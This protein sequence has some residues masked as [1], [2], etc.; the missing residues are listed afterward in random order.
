ML[1]AVKFLHTIIWAFFNLVLVY[2]FY[3]IAFDRIGTLFWIG[4]GLILFEG[5]ILAI[6]KWKCPLTYVARRYSDATNE[7]FDIYLPEWLAR[8][9]KTIYTTVFILLLIL[10]VCLHQL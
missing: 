5:L 9:N 4:I 1:T 2:V 10:Y 7:N 8:H 3:A 6:F